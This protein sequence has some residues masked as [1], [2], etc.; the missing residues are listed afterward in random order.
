MENGKLKNITLV[1]IQSSNNLIGPYSSLICDKMDRINQVGSFIA[2]KTVIV[3]DSV[4]DQLS[5]LLKG[6]KILLYSNLESNPGSKE[7]TISTPEE[8]LK[9]LRR[10]YDY[11]FI[12]GG[13]KAFLDFYQY[14]YKMLLTS[15]KSA[16]IND[17]KYPTLNPLE[18]VAVTS[19]LGGKL[20]PF[21]GHF[22][23]YVRVNIPE[24][25]NPNQPVTM[26]GPDSFRTK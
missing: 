14:S 25:K 13:Q 26:R 8:G 11:G 12:L 7:R 10:Q 18:W 22:Q 6:S 4:H 5:F 20:P 24:T 21:E 19:S 2:D 23:E 15:V 17:G 1:A 16:L 9:L 3:T